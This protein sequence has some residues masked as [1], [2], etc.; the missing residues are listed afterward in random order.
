MHTPE[1]HIII[2]PPGPEAQRILAREAQYVSPSLPKAYP[3]V[4]HHAKGAH[5]WDVDGNRYLDFTTGIAVTNLGHCHDRINAAIHDQVDRL[6]HMSNADFTHPEYSELCER[7]ATLAPGATPKKVLL[8]NSGTE[9]V[10]CAIKLAQHSFRGQ[11]PHSLAFYGAFHGRTA[12]SLAY[13]ASG[14]RQ[15]QWFKVISGVEHIPYPNTYQEKDIDHLDTLATT[16]FREKDPKL[17]SSVIMEPIQGEGGYL[18]PP[19][20]YM[21][22]LKRLCEEHGILFIADEVQTGMGRTGKM[23]CMEHYGIEPDIITL[24][25][26][27]ANGLPLGATI[28]KAEIMD[29]WGPGAHA[30]TFG[31]NP[32]AC[33]AALAV[34]EELTE[35]GVLEH[36]QAMGIYLRRQLLSL[37][38]RH[39]TIG[40]VRGM[41]LM[42][43]VEFVGDR[44]TR[45]QAPTLRDA[46]VHRC[47]ESGLLLLGCGPSAVRVIP[48]LNVTKEEIDAGI[49]I[50][51][52]VLRERELL[53]SP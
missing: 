12:G 27:I 2:S 48:S 29:S 52:R 49:A 6:L 30:S 15:R 20:W 47:F 40:D 8:S 9:A 4:V 43:G 23:F 37:L 41:G 42:V 45:E 38:Q 13:T 28:A 10:E 33:R 24:A 25:K 5:V 14:H 34:I 51:D 7:L 50:M 26:G 53:P 17:F 1:P 19:L 32:V 46:F 22:K 35:K 36:C 31:G 11:R 44:S 16:L 39:R 21:Q 3:L 18:V